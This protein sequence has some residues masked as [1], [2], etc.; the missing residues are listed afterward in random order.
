MPPTRLTAGRFFGYARD[1]RE[2]DSFSF[3]ERTPEL[4][5][6]EVPLHSH[7][8]AHFV[9]VVRGLY[10]TESHGAPEVCS[11]G[12]LV[13]NPR[14]TTHR[15]RFRSDDGIFFTV[16]VAPGVAAQLERTLP[17]AT[18]FRAP[19]VLR[20]V[21]RAYHAYCANDELLEAHG[22]E[23]IGGAMDFGAAADAH[24]DA[25]VDGSAP[26]WLLRGRDFLRET[27]PTPRIRDAAQ[28]AGVH[29]VHFARAF[30]RYFRCSPGDYLRECRLERA[31]TLLR[32]TT[33][34]LAE[35]A[36]E[37]G[38]CDQSELTHTF[39]R[40]FGW[41]PRDFRAR[42]FHPPKTRPDSGPIIGACST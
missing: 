12:A 36:H 11:T 24:V 30:R 22:L 2:S 32:T 21:S 5:E 3:V 41:T 28:V 27:V 38:F 17:R 20:A 13:F 7:D 40:T 35:V 1:A 34:T 42:M 23:L 14:G 39:T 8:E 25:S 4:R 18:F 15:D 10:V 31:T 37:A 29:P 9:F 19:H 6:R 26:R 33:L 16:G